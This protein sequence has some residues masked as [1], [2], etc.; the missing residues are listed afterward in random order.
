MIRNLEKQPPIRP[1]PPKVKQRSCSTIP[2]PSPTNEPHAIV[3]YPYKAAHVDELTCEPDD[4]VILKK[5][6]FF[7]F[8]S[9]VMIF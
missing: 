4:V 5:E 6:V 7:V 2:S 9:L 3:R 8:C 1:P